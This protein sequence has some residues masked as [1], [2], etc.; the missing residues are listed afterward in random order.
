MKFLF[1]VLEKGSACGNSTEPIFVASKCPMAKSKRYE[2]T[3]GRIIPHKR[4]V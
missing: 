2:T 1:A 4:I 3:L